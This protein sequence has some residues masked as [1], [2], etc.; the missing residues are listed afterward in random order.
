M[1]FYQE[2]AARNILYI[3]VGSE[4]E[5]ILY[6]LFMDPFLSHFNVHFE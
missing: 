5:I 6:Y 4:V 1:K 2:P 3:K